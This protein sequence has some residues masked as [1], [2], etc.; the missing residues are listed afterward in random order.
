VTKRAAS[1]PSRAPRINYDTM[2]SVE[3][4]ALRQLDWFF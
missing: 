2:S 1:H 4:S 3:Y